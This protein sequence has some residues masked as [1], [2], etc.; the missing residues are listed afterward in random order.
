MTQSSTPSRLRL[1]LGDQLSDTLSA[2]RGVDPARDTVLMA[3]VRDE[4]TYVRHHKQ[5][6]VLTFAAMRH[7][8]ARLERAGVRVRYVRIDD[9]D[10]CGSI[11]GELDRALA[12]GG[13]ES[14]VMTESGEWRLEQALTAWAEACAMSVER[15]ADDRFICSHE[16]FRRWAAD[17]RQLTMEFFYREMRRETGLLM[18][19]RDPVGGRWN[20]DAENRKKL[21]R[22]L[23]PPERLRIA[24]D[25]VTREAMADVQRLFPEHFGTLEAFGWPTTAEDAER[26]LGEF[27]ADILP[28]F[29]DWQDAMSHDAPFMWHALIASSL[30]LGLLD[31][32]DVC[33]RAEAAWRAGHAPLNAVEGF[34]RQILGWREFV[35]G[36]YW[37]KVPEYRARNFLDADR[38]LPGF[39]WSGETD[40]R[41]VAEAVA[42]ARDHAY[43][44]HIQR[45]MVTGN[46]AMLLGV[47]PDHVDD[48]Y[49]VVFAD[50]YEW[51]EM[52]NTRGMATFADGGIVGSKPY[53]ASGAYIHRMSDHCGGCRYDVQSKSGDEACPFNRL[54]WGFLER[55]RGRLRDNIRLA[56]P[57]RTLDG[58]EPARR[59]ALVDEAERCRDALGAVRIATGSAE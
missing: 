30:N 2:L 52:P 5:K 59:Q 47:H 10:N 15:R 44:H 23:R 13:F 54:Y 27:L 16:R 12:A 6:L 57:Y 18:D 9:P 51:V 58:M 7:F 34:I 56:M 33:R 42:S 19:G 25:A 20:F 29:G 53:A 55:N 38:E 1:V 46:L 37:L 40:M 48:W 41:C 26:V 8:A 50:A 17:K 39:Y 35:R 49:M 45:L 24:P 28:A 22:G 32:L 21:P 14:V 36:V 3:E 31:P 4:A 43:A 11:A